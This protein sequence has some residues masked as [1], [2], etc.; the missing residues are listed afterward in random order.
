MSRTPNEKALEAHD[1]YRQ[2]RLLVEISDALGVP[3]GTVRSWKNRQKWDCNATPKRNVAKRRGG[4]PGNKNAVGHASSSPAEN[5]NA[6]KHGFFSKWLPE[7][8]QEILQVI[9]G[10]NPLDL[11]WDNIQLQYAAIVRAQK[12]MHVKD[13][14]DMTKVLKRQKETSGLSFDGWEKEYELQF[15]WDKQ[16]NFL[17]AQSRA[18]KTLES[19][20]KQYDEMLHKDWAAATEEQKARIA[21]LKAKAQTDDP[22]STEDDGFMAALIG[23]VD[24]VWSDES[25]E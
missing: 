7:E 8:T 6:E 19:M 17:Q 11:L 24:E 22:G 9:G 14:D 4:Q 18:M 5:K 16:A 23:K 13:Q 15:A 3:V 12:I 25:G 1:L 21:A 2:G 20:I 10:S